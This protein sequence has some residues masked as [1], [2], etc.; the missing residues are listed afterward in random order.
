MTEH[1]QSLVDP[2]R[3]VFV[4]GVHRSGTTPLVKA[5]ASHPEISGLTYTN[6]R[7]DEGQHLQSVYPADSAV[8]GVGRFARSNAP[9][10][11][12]RSA[13]VSPQNASRLVAAWQPYWDMRRP[14]LVEKSPPNLLMGRFLQAMFPGSAL[15]V[16]VRHPVIVS[17]AS[18]KW[19]PRIISRHG[20]WRLTLRGLF[21]NWVQAHETFR[22]DVPHLS[23]VHV[24]YYEDLVSRPH[25]ELTRIQD[26]L[27][28]DTAPG[29]H[30]LRPDQSDRY[31]EQWTAMRSRGRLQQWHIER[32]ETEFADRVHHLGYDIHDL[33]R[34][35]TRALATNPPASPPSDVHS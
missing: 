12:E 17:L 31:R 34:T 26:F 20:R 21:K 30:A 22:R 4:G 8:G 29:T 19:S 1:G 24:V 16:I 33:D 10:L 7:E 28:L 9:H 18:R 14:L 32:I 3:L 13:L 35:T 5:L 6:V 2:R 11:T 23:R 27:M 25:E 15:I